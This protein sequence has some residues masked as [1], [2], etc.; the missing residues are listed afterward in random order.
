M[1]NPTDI[2]PDGTPT[3]AVV[4]LAIQAFKKR[5]KLMRLD[6]ESKVGRSP[7]SGGNRS[8]VAGIKPPDQYPQAV[9]DHLVAVGRLKKDSQGMYELVGP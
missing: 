1:T 4:K 5:I 2:N 3:A 9:W 6:D 8:I 7:M